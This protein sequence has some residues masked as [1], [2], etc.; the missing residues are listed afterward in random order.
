[1]NIPYNVI[2]YGEQESLTALIDGVL[3]AATSNHPN[4][5]RIVAGV[6]DGDADVADLFDVEKAINAAFGEVTDRVVVNS[7]GTVLLDGE[8][9]NG[10][11]TKVLHGLVKQ[12]DIKG[13]TA[14]ARFLENLEANP[15]FNSRE[16]LYNFVNAHDVS[17]DEDGY[18]ILYK[19]VT[20]DGQGGYQS[21]NSGTAFVNGEKVVGQIPAATGDVITMPREQVSDN[22][23]VACHVGLHVST[24]N[25]SQ[26]YARNGATLTMRVH[27]ADVVSVPNDSHQQKMRV[28][29]Y[30]VVDIVQSASN[31]TLWSG[32][33]DESD[34]DEY[35]D[36]YFDVDDE[37][38]D[39]EFY[40]D[41][42]AETSGWSGGTFTIS[43]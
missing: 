30:E 11:V 14:I 4:Y 18:L 7:D 29:K 8:P 12:G 34:Y 37:D 38:E 35:E 13:Y 6:K 15:S 33:A 17:I 39:D 1:M 28:C 5:P 19:G 26:Y 36:S 40:E 2:N 3:Y 22:P 21:V 32:R 23:A 31:R 27:P 41:D 20:S 25:Y 24:H 9:L 10:A 16:Q 42:E 43:W